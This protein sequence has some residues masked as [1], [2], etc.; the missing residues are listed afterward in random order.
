MTKRKVTESD[1]LKAKAL[2]EEDRAR[3]DYSG[4]P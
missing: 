3:S 2:W 1:L 4:L